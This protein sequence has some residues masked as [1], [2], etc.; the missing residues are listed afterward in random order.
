[1]IA[2]TF[3]VGQAVKRE[4]SRV[5]ECG[6]AVV[7]LMLCVLSAKG[8]SLDTRRCSGLPPANSLAQCLHSVQHGLGSLT[9]TSLGCR[10]F[11]GDAVALR[12]RHIAVD[13]LSSLP[14]YSGYA[15]A[16][17]ECPSM[18]ASTRVSFSRSYTASVGK[19]VRRG[20]Q[21]L[22]SDREAKS[23]RKARRP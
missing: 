16:V 17:P 11:A 22:R 1:M 5:W 4:P 3:R 18:N 9:R 6:A 21:R 14:K 19:P 8:R 15:D 13:G 12:V 10:N 2:T 7:T 20:E 23:R